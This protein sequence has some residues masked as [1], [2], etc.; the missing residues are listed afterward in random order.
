M[1][2]SDRRFDTDLI[3]LAGVAHVEAGK[4]GGNYAATLL[5][6]LKVL[7]SIVLRLPLFSVRCPSSFPNDIIMRHCN[8]P[9]NLILL[10]S[11]HNKHL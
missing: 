10:A 5:A 7:F 3:E 6:A 4:E 1:N 2:E 9:Q 8:Q 11:K